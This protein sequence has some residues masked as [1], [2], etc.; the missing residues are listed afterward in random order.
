MPYSQHQPTPIPTLATALQY[1]TADQLKMLAALAST[2]K[3]RPT[4]KAELIEFI[5][6]HIEG[7]NLKALWRQLDTLQQAAI[8]ETV[9]SQDSS[10]HPG[11]FSA[12]YGRAPN[13]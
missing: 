6:Q 7:D 13:W 10:F 1:Q 8:A 9:Y 2:D 3:R 5:Q 4:R 12:K 11:Q